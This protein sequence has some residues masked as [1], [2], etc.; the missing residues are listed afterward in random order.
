MAIKKNI[1]KD[2]LANAKEIENYA[3][4]SA[5]KALEESLSTQMDKT[6]RDILKDIEN[7]S[8]EENIE[9]N[10]KLDVAPD[11]TLTISV[12]PEGST[13]ELN[14]NDAEASDT[15]LEP[16]EPINTDSEMATNDQDEIYEVE[17]AGIEP[18]PN[19]AVEPT[20]DTQTM[21]EPEPSME[22]L[23]SQITDMASKIDSILN[24]VAPDAGA[25]SEGA[26]EVID[27]ETAGEMPAPT[28]TPAPGAPTAPAVD[29]TVV[30]ED[31]MMFEIDEEFMNAL[32]EELNTIKEDSVD[33]SLSEMN[34]L[35]EIE[36]VAEED[37]DNDEAEEMVDEMKGVGH[38]VQRSAGNRQGF[39][40][41]NFKHTPVTNEGV[42]K[43]KV[44][45]ESKLDELIQENESLKQ[46]VEEYKS[47]IQEFSSSFVELQ[48]QINEMNVF[49][50]KLAYANRLLSKGGLTNTE[51]IKIAESF[52]K[53]ESVEEAKKLYNNFLKEMKSGSSNVSTSE[54]NFITSKPHVAPQQK[55]TQSETIFESEERKRWKELAG[56][57]IISE[58][59]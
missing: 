48:K 32:A 9:E 41:N 35:D 22:N 38:T 47:N 54:V 10:I 23:Q 14:N 16:I 56:I 12:S 17:G 34:D 39:E 21:S 33:E 3:L 25:G 20:P 49:N 42:E 53:A 15:N 51:K 2:A 24:A 31:D 52:D 36:I 55:S 57:K 6:V 37:G 27:D 26:V 29:D 13:I 18:T 40:K 59:K 5:K 7:N 1:L 45:Y 43:I 50:G 44:Q 8:N 19:T 58:G 30:S 11:A 28:P 46:A 4:E